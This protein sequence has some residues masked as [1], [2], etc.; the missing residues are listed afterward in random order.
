VNTPSYFSHH[1]IMESEGLLKHKVEQWPFASA[2]RR[3][4][5]WTPGNGWTD[6]DVRPLPRQ[7]G[8]A[9]IR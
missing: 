4:V 9:A 5:E 2:S 7:A 3:I 6:H 1:R 8:T